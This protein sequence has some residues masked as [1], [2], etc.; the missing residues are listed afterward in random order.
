LPAEPG[1]RHTARYPPYMENEWVGRQL[2]VD[3]TRLRVLK[4]TS[5]CAP[6][7]STGCCRRPRTRS[8]H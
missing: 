5:R 6:R 3:E 1:D 8:A 4:L 7:S 2:A